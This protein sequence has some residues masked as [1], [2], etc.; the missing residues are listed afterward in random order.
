MGTLVEITVREPDQ[1][2]AQLAISSAFDEMRRLEKLMSTHLADSE[3]SR[4]NA[5]AGGKSSL[6]VS[7]EVL[8]VILRGIHWGNKSGGA[9]DISI[10]PVS[11]LWQFD[12]ENPS[13]PDSQR[14]A[15]AVPLV[16]FR[17][18]EINKSN[19]RLEQPGMSLQLGAI[20]KGYAVDKAMAVLQNNG[21]RHALINA[22]GDLKVMGQRKDGQPWS[23]GLQH[24]R[25]PEKLIASFALSDRAVATSGDYQKYFMKENTRYHHI[26]DPA[27]GMQA[28]GVISATIV[29]KTVMDADALATA[30]FVLG[31][32]KG[33]AL[34]DSLDGV[35]G[36]MVTASGT[37]LF[38][39]NFQS[40]PGFVF[41]GF[42]E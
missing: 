42:K 23:I 29:A 8:E 24:P 39:K 31:P 17:E 15:Q 25:Q 11:N 20:A 33:M 32:K 27:N 6:A 38:S 14:L 9:L 22:G 34:V 1:E 13:I 19:V 40:Q 3:I 2:K 4:L 37:T 21:I 30:V 41:Q 28:K 18:I 26:L 10:G 12:D 35:E 36:M 5:I 16:N 7:P